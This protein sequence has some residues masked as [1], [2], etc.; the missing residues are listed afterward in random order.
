MRLPLIL[1]LTLAPAMAQ[2]EDT[3]VFAAASLKTALD[4]IASQ[5]QEKTGDNLLI[6]Y[7]GSNAL[8]KQILEGAPADIF[9]SAAP[10]WTEAVEQAGLVQERVD[11]LGNSLV[12]IGHGAASPV[13]MDSKLDLAGLL[14]GGH[15]AMAM[16]DSVP[17]GQYGKAALQSLGLWDSVADHIAQTDNVRA[18]LALVETGEAPLGVVYASDAM[19]SDKVTVLASFPPDSHKPIT[20]PAVLLTN[21]GDPADLAFF[22]ALS[23]LEAS[24]IFAA[25]G[26]TPLK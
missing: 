17:A 10:N 12:L 19:A 15:L 4:A 14:D 24:A 3:V 8:A 23:A 25:N 7:A 22:K 26:F 1:A 16:V 5:W 11:L 18:A 20:Y 21:A 2:A 13:V 6:S 9:L